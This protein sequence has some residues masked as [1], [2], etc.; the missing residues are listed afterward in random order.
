MTRV[1]AF[2]GAR[3]EIWDR[4]ATRSGARADLDR[5]VRGGMEAYAREQAAQFR[6]MRG[7][8]EHAWMFVDDYVRQFG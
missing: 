3:A 7:R 4:Q 1:K 6:A 5:A 2:F 8:C